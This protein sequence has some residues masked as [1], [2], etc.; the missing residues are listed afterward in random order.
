[1]VATQGLRSLL[2]GPGNTA[3]VDGGAISGIAEVVAGSLQAT[4]FANNTIGSDQIAKNVLQYASVPLTSAQILAMFTTPVSLV[5]AGGA[6]TI[7]VPQRWMF[8]LIFNSV[9]Y[10]SGG[11]VNIQYGNTGSGGGTA[12][13]NTLAANQVTSGTSLNNLV[14]LGSTNIVLT[15][16]VNQGIFVTNATGVFATGNSTARIHLWY[17]L[18]SSI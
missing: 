13:G 18:N 1:M 8:T 10:T 17:T 15:P 3:G 11:T 6:N 12:I 16:G 4:N 9:A 7:L 14:M 2:P 5:A